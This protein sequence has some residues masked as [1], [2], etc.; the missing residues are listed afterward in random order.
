MT[1]TKWLDNPHLSPKMKFVFLDKARWPGFRP[2]HFVFSLIVV[3]CA[4]EFYG[5][6]SVSLD[7]GVSLPFDQM[8]ARR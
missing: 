5:R 7:E 6:T 8:K 2:N 1:S 3:L 4:I